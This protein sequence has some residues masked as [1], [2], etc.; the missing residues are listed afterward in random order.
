MEPLRQTEKKYCSLALTVA[1]IVGFIF[2]LAAQKAL[3]KGLILGTLFSIFN[4]ILIGETLPR[5]IASSSTKKS[6]F[7]AFG[8][9]FFRYTLMAV[10]VVTAI[11]SENY[12]LWTAVTGIFMVQLMILADHLRDYFFS[13]DSTRKDA[14]WKN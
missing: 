1:I 11:R 10:P 7:L 14:L 3:A 12:N 2:I 8:S 5:R 6:C 13:T 4:F 9:I